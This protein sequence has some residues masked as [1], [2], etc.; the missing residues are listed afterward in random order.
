VN[1]HHV[2]VLPSLMIG[3]RS[4]GEWPG[5]TAI[6]KEDLGLLGRREEG[7]LRDSVVLHEVHSSCL[8]HV[9]SPQH[10]LKVQS[11]RCLA[12]DGRV[13][14]LPVDAIDETS[15]HNDA[16]ASTR[17]RD[18][19]AVVAVLLSNH[20]LL[21]M[22][23]LRHEI[24]DVLQMIVG[25]VIRTDKPLILSIA[26]R[27]PHLKQMTVLT[28]QPIMIRTIAMRVDQIRDTGIALNIGIH[29]NHVQTVVTPPTRP[30]VGQ[31][32]MHLT[33]EEQYT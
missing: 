19:G 9:P 3:E 20:D 7:A 12:L 6:L 30:L 25:I 22:I 10:I 26:R 15:A 5:K 17:I 1:V 4:E 14:D 23:Q 24:I 21:R 29:L 28:P 31:T 18:A 32:V 33:N 2:G 8:R 16:R 11:N 27:G 13:P